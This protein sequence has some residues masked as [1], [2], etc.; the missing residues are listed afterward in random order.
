MKS[1][2]LDD[3]FGAGEEPEFTTM[4]SITHKL[5]RGLLADRGISLI[6]KLHSDAA[7]AARIGNSAAALALTEIAE[8]AE[9]EW[10]RQVGQIDLFAPVT[11]GS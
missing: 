6:W 7:T 4:T 8:A 3:Y 2:T 10:L 5:A 9:R 1:A 11:K